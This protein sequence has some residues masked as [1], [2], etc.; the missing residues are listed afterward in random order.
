MVAYVVIQVDIT[1]PVKFEEYKAVVPPIIARYGGRYLTRGGAY[2]VLCGTW[3]TERTTIL[4]FPTTADAQAWYD[5]PE[6]EGP[7]AIRDQG[8]NV[9]MV[10]VEGVD[11][12]P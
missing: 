7:K 1:D 2:E 10:V 8:A 9:N 11:D 5:S 3:P 6:Y 12:V 4:E